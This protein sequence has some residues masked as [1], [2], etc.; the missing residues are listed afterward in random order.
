MQTNHTMEEA[1][2]IQKNFEHLYRDRPGMLGVGVC[3]TPTGKFA[4]NVQ[5]K[6]AR[7]G[8]GLPKDFFGLDV[9]TNVVGS[10]TAL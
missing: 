3:K 9:V 1:V 10:I 4:L 7:D 8:E 2:E 6:S 5:L